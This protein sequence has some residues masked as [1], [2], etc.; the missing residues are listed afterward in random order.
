MN[1]T[2]R[3]AFL[4]LLCSSGTGYGQYIGEQVMERSFEQTDFFFTPYRLVPYGIGTF[5]NSVAGVLDDP[6]LNLDVNPAYLYSD[7]LQRSYAYLDFRNA[8]EIRDSR[9]VYFP[10]D[11]LRAVKVSMAF[12]PYPRFY[13]NTRRALEPVFSA[14]YLLRPAEGAFKN[15][16]LGL[17]YQLVSQDEK[18]Y[19]IPQDI[20]NPVLG[21]DYLG[22][23]SAA[24]ENV[25]IVDKYSGADDMHQ[26]GHFVSMFAGY[27][28]GPNLQIGAKIGRVSF[29]REG[30]YGSQNL[31]DSYYAANNTSLWRD[32]EARNQS[33]RHWELAGGVNYAIDREYNVGLSGGHLWGDA[34]QAVTHS[35][36]SY[37]SSGRIGSTTTGWNLYS[38]SG[39]QTQLWNHAGKVSFVAA[40]L[41]ARVQDNQMVQFH[42]Q[43]TRENTAITLGGLI[44]DTSYGMANYQWNGMANDY[45]SES[46]L[47]D[48]RNGT[49]TR[50]GNFHQATGS[51]QWQMNPK[52]KLSLGLQ[53]EGQSV[54]T[55][56][57]ETVWAIRHSR[58]S[59]T[60]SYPSNYFDSTAE[61]KTLE[62]TFPTK[63]TRFTVPILFT[64]R[65]SD[66]VELIFGLNRSASNWRVDD[67]TLAL[68]DYRAHTST[69]DTLFRKNF[70]ERYTQPPERS[71]DVRTTLLL[72]FT[73]APSNAFSLRFLFVPVFV[74]SYD[75]SDL[76]DLQGWIS[77]NLLL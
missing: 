41:K 4:L 32:L 59:S 76:S 28:I 29:D 5:S 71:S 55:N 58:S 40:H 8:R 17:T 52:V 48:R 64:I 72:G 63:L 50:V 11:I 49:G 21:A 46:G 77:I 3:I 56:T 6:I 70:G 62:W 16:S 27:E 7:T 36:S 73:A 37:W 15:L 74:D 23:R 10:Y 39:T 33:Y 68:F 67:V 26:E 47:I 22:T 34:D 45:A 31:W 25:P 14:A 43:Y 20:Y 69:Q 35:D 24:A 75:G 42:Y 12:Y 44:L 66:A 57:S 9:S 65:T 61:S 54:E 19:P 13:V 1:N 30:S 60:G 53:Y 18:Y 51:L 38:R 2:I